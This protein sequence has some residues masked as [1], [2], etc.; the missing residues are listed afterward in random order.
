MK[1]IISILFSII[2]VGLSAQI[3]QRTADEIVKQPEKKS[4]IYRISGT[5]LKTAVVNMN[6]GNS[7]ILSVMDRKELQDADIIQIDVV[8][9]NYPKGEDISELNK[10]RILK[11]SG[12]RADLI[13][14]RSI[15]WSM[16]RQM[17]CK[18]E[19]QAKLLF[20]GAVIYY[21]PKP[22]EELHSYELE[23]Y[24][25]LPKDDKVKI[26]EASLK[27]FSDDPVIIKVM[28]RNKWVN[29]T[30]VA[31]VTGSMNP[32]MVQM[33]YWFLLKLNQKEKVNITFFNDGDRKP[34]YSKI[35]GRTGG[36]YSASTKDYM[37]FRD[38][39]LKAV[40][41]GYGGD[42]PENDA[43]AIL[44]AQRKFPHAKE[45][46]LIA[47]N[48]SNMRDYELIKKIKKPVRVLLCG[49]KF[50]INVQYLNLARETGGSVHTLE[51][52]LKDLLEKSEGDTFSFMG[53]KYII[54]DGRIVEKVP[55]FT[56]S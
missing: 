8:Y 19:A 12:I 4:G 42:A 27:R 18:D 46:I 25:G 36:I 47:D 53:K 44:T 52:D 2:T 54:L 32:Y 17:S 56:K 22:S 24:N 20:H 15:S 55:N 35:P 33:A 29:P 6:Y 45:I 11:I 16:V 21:Q 14:N 41:N 34:N 7:D 31:D 13:K 39:L 1:T 5:Y 26:T 50:G 30:I 48:F 9:T 28:E 43:E 23:K 40:S 51:Q 3:P 37:E 38:T 10:Q 49:T